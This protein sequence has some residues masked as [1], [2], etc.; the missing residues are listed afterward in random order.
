MQKT[1]LFFV[2]T[3]ATASYSA[4]A[5]ETAQRLDRAASV[6]SKTIDSGRGIAAA[7]LAD[8]DCVA[9]I[10]G[11]KKG[12]A[13]VGVGY[14]KGFISCR[15]GN[16]WSAPGAITMEVSSLGAQ[17]GGEDFDLVMLSLNQ[18]KRSKL[19]SEKFTIGADASASWGNGKSAN[20]DSKAQI[21]V[22]SHST[23]GIFAGFALDGAT[24]KRDESTDKALYGKS[25]TT[26]Q[27][28]GDAPTPAVA[29]PLISQLAQIARR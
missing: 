24:V 1:L 5:D 4:A 2:V 27:I 23:K 28:V 18:E 11:F 13:G 15:N 8:A 10:P 12:A 16:G 26:S 21:V 9:V 6:L 29:Q 22:Y 19:L 25:W 14:G 3:A 20:A 17:I 7:H